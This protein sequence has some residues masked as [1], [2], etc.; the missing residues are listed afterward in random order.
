MA[1]GEKK[2]KPALFLKSGVPVLM[3]QSYKSEIL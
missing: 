3:N 2:K 1:G